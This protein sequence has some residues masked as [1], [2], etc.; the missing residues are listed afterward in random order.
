MITFASSCQRKR[1]EMWTSVYSR[2]NGA[3]KYASTN[4]SCAAIIKGKQNTQM[5]KLTQTHY[6]MKYSSRDTNII[7]HIFQKQQQRLRDFK[8]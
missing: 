2:S 5:D 6:K 4:K 3:S 1:M 7:I 8:Q